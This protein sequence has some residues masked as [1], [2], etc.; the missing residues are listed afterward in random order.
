M[1]RGQ[2]DGVNVV[3]ENLTSSRCL[4]KTGFLISLMAFLREVQLRSIGV[5]IATVVNGSSASRHHSISG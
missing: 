1:V 3:A 4:L 5:L 2:D